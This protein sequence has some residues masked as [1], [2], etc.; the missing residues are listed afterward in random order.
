MREHPVTL[1]QESR[2]GDARPL[3]YRDRRR[4][5]ERRVECLTH[6][7]FFP[8]PHPHCTAVVGG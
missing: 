5:L 4:R 8:T 6:D 2:R 1:W 3:H 7:G